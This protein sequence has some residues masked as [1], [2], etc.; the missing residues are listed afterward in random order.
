VFWQQVKAFTGVKL[1]ILHPM[2]WAR[3][4]VDLAV[5]TAKDAAVILC[6]MW[7]VWTARNKRRHG[8]EVMPVGVSVRWATDT[9]FDLCSWLIRSKNRHQLGVIS[10]PG[11]HRRRDG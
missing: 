7:A 2:T 1:P 11:E 5:L 3:D 8:E 10:S 9:V 4:I 6:G